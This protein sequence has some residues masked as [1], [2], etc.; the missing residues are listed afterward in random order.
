MEKAPSPPILSTSKHVEAETGLKQL[1]REI[2]G[3]VSGRSEWSVNAEN[4]DLEL[5]KCHGWPAIGAQITLGIS[6]PKLARLEVSQR[7]WHSKITLV[8]QTVHVSLRATVL[9]AENGRAVLVSGLDP[10]GI[11]I[12]WPE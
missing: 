1:T 7:F 2:S 6:L 12:L 8:D 5:L 11:L 3:R 10:S 9:A 4:V